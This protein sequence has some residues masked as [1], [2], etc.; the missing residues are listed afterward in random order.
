MYTHTE[1]WTLAELLDMTPS[2]NRRGYLLF[3]LG[4]DPE[5]LPV[6]PSLL[7]RQ[8]KITWQGPNQDNCPDHPTKY[9]WI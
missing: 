9:E 2:S 1:T 4:F 6:R 5:D 7:K 8:V 3:M